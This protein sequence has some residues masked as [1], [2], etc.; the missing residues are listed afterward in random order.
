[1]FGDFS[2][3]FKLIRI[4]IHILLVAWFLLCLGDYDPSV[5]ILS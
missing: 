5:G 1:M 2:K 4:A 3:R